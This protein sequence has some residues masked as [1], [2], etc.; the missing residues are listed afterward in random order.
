MTNLKI[1]QCLT[2]VN[3]TKSNRAISDIKYI[4]MHYVGA[5]GGAEANC[6]YFRD[7]FVGASAGYFVGHKGEIWQSVL[8]K[9]IAW[10]WGAN[11][12]KHSFARNSNSI[13]IEMCCYK[14]SKGNWYFTE[15][16]VVSA[17]ALAAALCKK[18]KVPIDNVLRHYDVTGKNCPEPY[19]RAPGLWS[20]FI[21]RTKNKINEVEDLNE[22]QTRKVVQEEINKYFAD[23]AKLPE[24]N[25]SKDDGAL[26]EAVAK[27]ITDGKRPRSFLTREEGA[28]MIV[29]AR[30]K[31]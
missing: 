7:N 2:S 3:R 28:T 8:D 6:R 4:G 17:I 20:D 26:A 24:S 10:H 9:D 22:A 30:E 1:K 25:W 11:S 21:S 16:T 27:G 5:T 13:G 19:V 18:Y 23:R 31:K 15:E 29:R 14:D 12:Y